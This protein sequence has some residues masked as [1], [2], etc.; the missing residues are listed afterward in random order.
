VCI[1]QRSGCTKI[2]QSINGNVAREI[3]F[4]KISEEIA[5][6]NFKEYSRRGIIY[7]YSQNQVVAK[8]NLFNKSEVLNDMLYSFQSNDF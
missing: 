3:N 1:F 7:E 8:N 4:L 2:V 6:F 5:E